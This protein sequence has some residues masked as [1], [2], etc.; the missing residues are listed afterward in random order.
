MAMQVRVWALIAVLVEAVGGHG[1]GS[2]G[3]RRGWIRGGLDE[4]PGLRRAGTA[5]CPMMWGGWALHH[6]YRYTTISRVRIPNDQRAIYMTNSRGFTCLRGNRAGPLLLILTV[7][8]CELSDSNLVTPEVTQRMVPLSSNICDILQQ[9]LDVVPP[10]TCVLLSQS[11]R[12]ALLGYFAFETFR[13]DHPYCSQLQNYYETLMS[14]TPALARGTHPDG[15]I[16]GLTAFSGSG[17]Y[18][19][20]FEDSIVN[21]SVGPSVVTRVLLHEMAHAAW[22]ASDVYADAAA[23]Y[24]AG[25]PTLPGGWPQPV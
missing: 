25:G 24:C 17:T 23:D 14:V 19:V 15:N 22:G 8:A 4:R 10:D 11:E 13:S 21:G 7:A 2:G 12:D 6:S 9:S 20:W 3:R 5:A 1:S 18:G 16:A